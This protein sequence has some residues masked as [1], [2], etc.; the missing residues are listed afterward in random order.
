MKIYVVGIGPGSIEH[1]TPYAQKAIEKSDVVVGYTVYVDLVKEL[2]EGKEVLSTP[3]KKE[4]D[5][6]Q[7]ALDA[8]L[9]NKTVAFVCSGDYSGMQRSSTSWRTTYPRF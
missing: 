7:M 5:R 9:E 3:M 8:A 4:V 2:T 1:M 6:C